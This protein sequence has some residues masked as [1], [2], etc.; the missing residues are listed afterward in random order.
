MSTPNYKKNH[1]NSERVALLEDYESDDD[2]FLK[3]PSS[4]SDKVRFIKLQ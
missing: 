2:F 3:G 1:R 4:A